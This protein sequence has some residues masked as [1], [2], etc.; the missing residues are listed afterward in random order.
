MIWNRQT[1]HTACVCAFVLALAVP[2]LAAAGHGVVLVYHHVAE[3]TPASTSISPRQFRRHLDYL[4]S[5][6]FSVWPL[7]R[8][9]RHIREER[10]VPA[11]TAA[12]TFDDAYQ[13]VYTTAF[14]LLQS[15][16]WPFTVFVNTAAID[17]GA[18]PYMNWQQLR[19][20]H[21]AGV[22]IGN[23]SH[24]HEHLLHRPA[25]T[26]RGQW[27][28]RISADLDRAQQR[29]K[30]ELGVS[31]ALFAYPYGEFSP[32]VQQ[33]VAGMGFS[34]AFGQHSGPMGAASDFLAL[35]RFPMASPYDSLER[36]AERLRT[37][38]LQVTAEPANGLVTRQ[39]QPTVKLTLTT[40]T[41]GLRCYA[42]GQ[43]LMQ[44]RPKGLQV[45]IQ[46][47]A[48]LKVGR[49]KFNCTAPHPQQAGAYLWWSY[50]VMRPNEDGSWYTW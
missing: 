35:P 44:M 3:D 31:A 37:E 40:A 50:L 17:R 2:D 5:H 26:T 47:T 15:R 42:S 25:G 28:E 9:V 4:Q 34:A 27:A 7:S 20:L 41:A 12:I 14:P 13:S 43:G 49:T 19:T 30:T 22:E 29:I 48:P 32:A 45:T 39:D 16:G 46:P 1:L 11:N 21:A 18:A 36:L 38:P 33:L 24:E 23:H 8:L 6:N 10:D